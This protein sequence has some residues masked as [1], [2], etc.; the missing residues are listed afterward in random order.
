MIQPSTIM[1]PLEDVFDLDTGTTVSRSTPKAAEVVPASPADNLPV[2]SDS[3]QYD[4]RDLTI[5]QQLDVIQQEAL[6]LAATLKETIQYSEPKALARLGEVSVQALNTALDVLK[7]KADIK[8]HK[9]KLKS[10]GGFDSVHTTT[11]NTLVIDRS[12][13]LRRALEGSIS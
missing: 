7:Q 6:D 2:A 3:S 5:E 1:H 8:K 13:L 10:T 12:E 11:H 9:D 4:G